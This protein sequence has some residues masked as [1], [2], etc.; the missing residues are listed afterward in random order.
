MKN[1]IFTLLFIF[2]FIIPAKADIAPAEQINYTF[3]FEGLPP[4]EIIAA[5]SSQIQCADNQCLEPKAL[6]NFGLQKFNCDDKSCYA[7]F[8]EMNNYQKIIIAFKDGTVKES[9]IFPKPQG[10]K[11][12]VLV[13][14]NP[15]DLS[16]RPDNTAAPD[17]INK[18]YAFCA[19]FFVLIA[20]ILTALLF[21]YINELPL[22]IIIWFGILN[23][24]T[25]PLNW[26]IL[27]AYTVH[28][29]LLWLAAFFIE[30]AVLALIYKRKCTLQEIFGLTL[31]SN[32]S[33]YCAGMI[34]SF[35]LTFF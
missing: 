13:I 24:I 28:D 35:I 10:R 26:F 19:M 1:F 32:V 16:V 5:K 31:F 34:L 14:V 18:T 30:F 22:K 6:G 7:V 11:N 25:I 2:A 3:K 20:E 8:Y 15:Q 17:R 27:S 4:S 33:G 9:Q 23:L 12:S 29:G 21:T